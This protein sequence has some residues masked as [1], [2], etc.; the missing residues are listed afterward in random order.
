MSEATRLA[1]KG[2]AETQTA[3]SSDTLFELDRVTGAAAIIA[4]MPE[5]AARDVMNR[6][7]DAA[8]A[9]IAAG[10]SRVRLIPRD[11]LTRIIEAFLAELHRMQ[12]ALRGGQTQAR[13]LLGRLVEPDRYRTLFGQDEPGKPVAGLQGDVW[14]AL[15]K[16]P[17]ER[18]ARYLE[19]LAPDLS[20]RVL[21]R[22]SNAASSDVIALMDPRSLRPT[23]GCMLRPGKPDPEVD[24]A[25]EHML[26]ENLLQG[27]DESS[28]DSDK[29]AMEGVAEILS[30]LPGDKRE[31]LVSFLRERHAERLAAVE[32]SLLTLEDI[33]KRLKR[34]HVPMVFRELGNERMT[35]ILAAIQESHPEAS[36]HLLANISS[37]LADQLRATIADLPRPGGDQRDQLQRELVAGLMGLKRRGVIALEA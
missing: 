37:R 7:N 18:L 10:L 12:G 16:I 14:R 27:N 24:L 3:L 22:L 35:Q 1:G 8:V 5:D 19:G 29:E 28:T 2:Y 33:P 31:D 25:L 11:Q 21:L 17:A 36:N 34:E 30:L 15:E 23:L 4:L 20:A 13:E 9:E 26:A 6:L 32:R